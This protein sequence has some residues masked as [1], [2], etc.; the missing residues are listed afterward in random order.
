MEGLGNFTILCS[1]I[2]IEYQPRWCI[3]MKKVI[4]ATIILTLIT[5][6]TAC[7]APVNQSKDKVVVTEPAKTPSDTPKDKPDDTIKQPEKPQET[8]TPDKPSASEPSKATDASAV[9]IGQIDSNSIEVKINGVTTA[10]F[11]S[12]SVKNSF[13]S[14]LFKRDS[15]VLVT[16]S[17]NEKGQNILTSIKN[18]TYGISVSG[19]YVGQIDNN[20][21]EVKIN[22]KAEA[23]Y[24]SDKLHQSFKP[25]E[26]KNG[27]NVRL[28]YYKNSK[29][30]T[31]LTG[32]EK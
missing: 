17:K 18:S 10:L 9:Y 27:V 23:F 21:I 24:L 28:Y 31:V 5:V 25:G 26:F 15:Q 16:Y 2:V 13:D 20:S 22:G 3:N 30:Q 11:F 8:K 1:Y 12:N 7:K 29:G 32:I 6:F 14:N 4:T 19:V